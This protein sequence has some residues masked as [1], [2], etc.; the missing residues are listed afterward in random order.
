MNVNLIMILQMLWFPKQVLL[1]QCFCNTDSCV[2]VGKFFIDS[3]LK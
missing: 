2:S 3:L 1:F